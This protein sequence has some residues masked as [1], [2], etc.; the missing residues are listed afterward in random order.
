MPI[1]R[2]KI[3]PTREIE[4]IR[5]ITRED[6]PRLLGPRD[7]SQSM[8]KRL[9]DSHHTVARLLAMG[10]SA[11]LVAEMTGYSHNRV[12]QLASSPAMIEL[13]ATY[14]AKIDEIWDENID[15]YAALAV[16]NMIAAE[17][18]L[19]DKLDAADEEGELLPTRELI[20]ISRDA[21]DR[22]GYGKRQTNVNVNADFA[23]MLEKA[24][25][26]SGKQ[27]EG[28]VEPQPSGSATLR[29]FPR[30]L[31]EPEPKAAE[32]S[33]PATNQTP[34]AVTAQPLIRRRA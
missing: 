30:A 23:S 22:F 3:K 7:K 5:S 28:T 15:A 11:K 16:R 29:S 6:L 17:R 19:A 2:G 12:S 8:P 14:R 25:A 13:V 9:R 18:Q 24:I 20:A 21:A 10:H 4:S 1:P 32:A 27:I 31:A 34:P 26:R 33:P